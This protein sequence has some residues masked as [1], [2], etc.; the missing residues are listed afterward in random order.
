MIRIVLFLRDISTIQWPVVY[1]AMEAC[2]GHRH[3]D[4]TIFRQLAVFADAYVDDNPARHD[5]CSRN[6]LK[7]FRGPETVW[8]DTP[9]FVFIV[10]PENDAVCPPDYVPLFMIQRKYAGRTSIGIDLR[11]IP[12]INKRK[13]LNFRL[14]HF[15]LFI[16]DRIPQGG[17]HSLYIIDDTPLPGRE[18]TV[19]VHSQHA[20]AIVQALKYKSAKSTTPW[21]RIIE[22]ASKSFYPLLP[23][24]EHLFPVLFQ[25]ENENGYYGEEADYMRK[26]CEKI[27]DKFKNPQALNEIKYSS[28]FERWFVLAYFNSFFLKSVDDEMVRS[29]YPTLHSYYIGIYELVQNIIFHTKDREG[30]IYVY[31]CKKDN[32]PPSTLTHLQEIQG[33]SSDM[34]LRLGIYD[35]CSRGIIQTCNDNYGSGFLYLT[36]IADPYRLSFL[37]EQENDYLSLTYAA[38][39]GIKTLVSSVLSHHGYFRIETSHLGQKQLVE[40][41][42]DELLQQTL[43]NIEGTHYD[44]VLPITKESLPSY[45][46]Q[47]DSQIQYLSERVGNAEMIPSIRMESILTDYPLGYIWDKERQND[48]LHTICNEIT[49]EFEKWGHG[50]QHSFYALDMMDVLSLTPNMVFKIL[51]ALQLRDSR[52]R[53]IVLYNLDNVMIDQICSIVKN[54]GERKDE[55]SQP[56]WSRE[57]AVVLMSTDFRAQIL[58]GENK[59]EIASM[60]RYLESRYFGYTNRFADWPGDNLIPSGGKDLLFPYEC[61]IFNNGKAIFFN[62]ISTLLDRSI[63]TNPNFGFLSEGVYSKIG[64]KLYVERFYSA[65]TLFLNSFFVD[66]F[67]YFIANDIVKKKRKELLEGKS[68]VLIGYRMFSDMTMRRTQQYITAFTQR[69]GVRTSINIIIVED[70][71]DESI[72]RFW[73]EVKKSLTKDFKDSILVLMVPVA[74][75]LTTHYKIITYFT[76]EAGMNEPPQFLN[77]CAILARDRDSVS[78]TPLE[79]AWRWRNVDDH[80]VETDLSGA[81]GITYCVQKESRWHHLIDKGTFPSSYVD[82]LYLNRTGDESMNSWDMFGFPSVSLP[83]IES[84]IH[85]VEFIR[86]IKVVDESIALYEYNR[87]TLERLKE[88]KPYIHVGHILYGA[89]HQRY[90]F[91]TEQYIRNSKHP[92]LNQWLEYLG[93]EKVLWKDRSRAPV[94]IAPE[95]GKESTFINMVNDQLFD[96]NAL[97][98]FIDISDA[99]DKIK[100]DYAFLANNRK[101]FSFFFVD[102]AILSAETYEKTRICLSAIYDDPSFQ[103][104]GVLA[105]L[106]RLSPV[107]YDSIIDN[108]KGGAFLSFLSLFFPPSN[109]QGEKCTLCEL[110]NHYERLLDF[111]VIE[112]CR[113]RISENH[114][115]FHL[116]GIGDLRYSRSQG[117][118]VGASSLST[119]LNEREYKRLVVSHQLFFLITCIQT[120]YPTGFLTGEKTTHLLDG[121]NAD[122]ETTVKRIE[123]AL[124]G[125]YRSYREDIDYRIS[126]IKAISF[127]PLSRYVYIRIF[128]HRLVLQ[129]LES[130]LSKEDPDY[131]DFCLMKVLLKSL[132]WQSSN[133]LVRRKVIIE[134]WKL[135]YK[136]R[137]DIDNKL[138]KV[139][140]D[141][142]ASESPVYGE[143]VDLFLGS[144][145]QSLQ[146]KR[147]SYTEKLAKLNDFGAFFQFCIKNASFNNEAQSFFLGEL[148]RTGDEINPLLP[149]QASKT[150]LN[151][152]LFEEMDGIKNAFHK[153]GEWWMRKPHGVFLS[154][155]YYD[156]TTIFRKTLSNFN[157]EIAK[158]EY[159]ANL[160][161]D[162]QS[163]RILP[164]DVFDKMVYRI[165][166]RLLEI[167]NSQYYYFWFRLLLAEDSLNPGLRLDYTRDGIPLIRKFVYLLYAQKIIYESDEHSFEEDVEK[168][169]RVCS[170]IM[171]TSHSFITIRYDQKLY[172][173][174]KYDSGIDFESNQNDLF[175]GRYLFIGDTPTSPE[176]VMYPFIIHE[177]GGIATQEKMEGIS[178]NRLCCQFLERKEKDSRSYIGAVTYLYDDNDAF[179]RIKKMECSRILLLL[180]PSI[181]KYVEHC[182]KEKLF[183]FWFKLKNIKNNFKRIN[184]TSNHSLHLEGWDF[185]KLDLD[186]YLRLDNDI[187]TLSNVVISHLFSILS[188]EHEIKIKSQKQSIDLIFSEKFLAI[189]EKLNQTR[190]SNK[191]RVSKIANDNWVLSENRLIIQSFVIQCIDNAYKKLIRKN[192][193]DGFYIELVYGSSFIEVKNNFPGIAD[194]TIE[195]EMNRFNTLYNDSGSIENDILNDR[196]SDYGMTLLSL[197]KYCET[198]NLDCTYGFFDLFNDTQFRVYLSVKK[199]INH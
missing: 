66:R 61:L 156:N 148:L 38:H 181:D 124:E 120:R 36:D 163:H 106:N 187:F 183:Q 121:R 13:E 133:A 64:S 48:V 123:E 65:D 116:E 3:V 142:F 29:I 40:G 105:L 92:L 73:P 149:L 27:L 75:T 186:N 67:A 43:D 46:V 167:V 177:K 28:L 57:H 56:I 68:V 145:I 24:D 164:F 104:T 96:G 112:P 179:F 158:D 95:Y 188:V 84:I 74:S 71:K 7:P 174:A 190:W 178:P 128:A 23:I 16:V 180:K 129:E 32:L 150:V 98:I 51:A 25:N 131:D 159:L 172:T 154:N 87:M 50:N 130:V 70:G 8:Q 19:P 99:I 83:S 88:F 2:L 132:S 140:S 45:P 160:F 199:T 20:P 79:E 192:Y 72:L 33:D 135:C 55:R 42:G 54:V 118:A 175:C 119:G 146:E 17:N 144:E 110:S 122:G 89:N 4:E 196:F 47:I 113:E 18:M 137:K 82:E 127:P 41:W 173:L 85:E 60:N 52:I 153:K 197:K 39:L 152:G 93:K 101:W 103:F 31:F 176:R 58:C 117:R 76:K 22:S 81:N 126:F 80:C 185:E 21:E 191:L 35:F 136:V 37:P 162:K 111:S 165:T 189:L 108:L 53:L 115:K 9:S 168:L 59:L 102:H 169:L 12:N 34:Y 143:T 182:I 94:I 198:R 1:Q 5:V 86:K 157:N 134:S 14:S 6:K 195:A 62:Y 69:E 11:Q 10:T 44:I 109:Q 91:D 147:A 125:F 26:S 184:L 100:A 49:K 90:Y 193:N 138:R 139:E 78:V 63:S 170:A 155:V 107:K 166:E 15:A 194:V 77:Y 97:I 171:D 151:N 114:K 141:L 161:Y 30:W